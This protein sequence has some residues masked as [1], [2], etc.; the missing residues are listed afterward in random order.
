M[1]KPNVVTKDELIEAAKRCIL[2]KGIH[3]LTLRSVAEGAGVT[4]GTVYYHFGSKDQLML[5]IVENMC[6]S[7]W[8]S[9]NT[10][11]KQE[12]K[13]IHWIQ[14]ALRSAHERTTKDAYF[15]SLFVSLIVAGLNNEQIR[16]KLGKM[17]QFENRVLKE[18]MEAVI[19][20]NVLHGVSLDVWSVLFNAL[21]DGL[22]IQ[23]LVAKETDLDGL[24]HELNLLVNK[25]LEAST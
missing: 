5:E 15:H 22:A 10:M 16:E 8:N 24:Y 6:T 9:L 1:A 13:N 4:Q 20:N 12:G 21:I 2:E 14:A 11:S 19:G 18:Q 17:L 3:R 23:A 25:L 7:S